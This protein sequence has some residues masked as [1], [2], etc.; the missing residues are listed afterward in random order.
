MGDFD[1]LKKEG[2]GNILKDLL[3]ELYLKHVG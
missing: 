1:I 2:K 3:V